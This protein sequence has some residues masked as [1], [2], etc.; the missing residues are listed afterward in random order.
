[1]PSQGN[2]AKRRRDDFRLLE[3]QAVLDKITCARADMARLETVYPLAIV[4]IYAW[5]FANPPVIKSLW[6]IA[7][8]IP[9]GIAFFSVVR[10]ASRR[11]HIGLLEAYVRDLETEV[12]GAGSELGWERSYAR[13]NPLAWLI[14]IR[15]M[16]AVVILGLTIWMALKSGPLFDQWQAAKLS[17][18]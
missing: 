16:L 8:V 3:Y 7:L 12:Y 6:C 5:V 15:A 14:W 2:D 13:D 17:G 18:L 9:V 4:A 11:K 10:I 1:M